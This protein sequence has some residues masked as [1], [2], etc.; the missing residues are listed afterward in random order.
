M[1]QIFLVLFYEEGLRTY[2]FVFK[3]LLLSWVLDDC[4]LSIDGVLFH[5]V[6]EH[7]FDG[8]AVV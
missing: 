1:L 8:A 7:T 5:L 6:R 4:L 2:L 3:S